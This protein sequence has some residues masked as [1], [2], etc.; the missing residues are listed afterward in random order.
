MKFIRGIAA[1]LACVMVAS[2]GGGKSTASTETGPTAADLTLALS[3]TSV[4]DSGSETVTATVNV[5][6]SSRNAISGVPV[7]FSVD[8]NAVVVVNKSTTD[9]NGQIQA[10]VQI[11]SDKSNRV[12]TLTAKSGTLVRTASFTVTGAKIQAAVYQAVIAPGGSGQIDYTVKD[13]NDN[14]LPNLPISISAPGIVGASGTTDSLG[15]YSF[16]YTAPA[17]NGTLQITASAAGTTSQ[18]NIQVQSGAGAI[19][20]VTQTIAS[21]SATVN[22]SVVGVNSAGTNNSADIRALFLAAGNLP[23][24][25]MRVKFALNDLYNVGGV[26]SSGSN[27]VYSD[28]SGVAV[29]TYTPGSRSSP[30]NG[31]NI[32]VCYYKTDAEAAAADCLA[33]AD[34]NKYVQTTLTVASEPLSVSIGTDN[35]VGD[36]AGGLTYIKKFVVLVVDSSGQAKSD[37]QITPSVDLL[38]YIKGWYDGPQAWNRNGPPAVLGSVGFTGATCLNE[39]LNRNGALDSNEDYNKN[40]SLDPRKSDVAIQMVGSSKTDTSGVAILQIEYPKNIATWVN[41]KIL[42]SASGIS[43]TEGRATWTGLLPAAAAEFKAS[44]S[45]SFVVSPYGLGNAD[46]NGDGTIDCLDKD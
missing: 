33:E 2:C 5:V 46:S 36:G 1:L 15:K 16:V 39:D 10:T 17:G 44:A 38:S 20:S 32:K 27:V 28:A 31:V 23:I 25:N 13:A 8:S 9:T 14:P 45:P 7:S 12:I 11:G 22:P 41:F 26:I 43:G 18:Q 42:V 40:G 30:T 24:P 3:T 6:D 4:K 21:A 35:T 19:P 34:I 29:S 37:V